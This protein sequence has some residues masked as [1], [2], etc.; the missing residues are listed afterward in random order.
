MTLGAAVVALAVAVGAGTAAAHNGP[1][2]GPLV[3]GF[4]LGHGGG[5][6]KGLAA[7]IAAQKAFEADVAKRLGVTVAKLNEAAKT[8]AKAKV[9]AAR[10][11]DELTADEATALK[12]AIDDGTIPVKGLGRASDVAKALGTT[13]AKLNEA[14]SEARKAQATARVDQ[15]VKD[16]DLD[17][18]DAAKLK[19]RIEDA[20][21]PGYSAGRPFGL[22]LGPP[23]GLGLGFGKH[24]FRR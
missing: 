17:A 21:F 15:A 18:D 12:E 22:G 2:G 8:A 7:A 14:Y 3:G 19:D 9:D 11:D 4:A 20:D 23:F 24:V 5:G 10:E 16:G 13:V 1:G 6:L